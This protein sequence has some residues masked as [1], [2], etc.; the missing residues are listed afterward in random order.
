MVKNNQLVKVAKVLFVVVTFIKKLYFHLF[1]ITIRLKQF[2]FFFGSFFLL[3]SCTYLDVNKSKKEFIKK[4]DTLVDFNSV[5]AFPLFPIC[6]DVP[7][8]EKQQICFQL[9]MSQYIYAGIKNYKVM[10]N[11]E[12]NDTVFVKLIVDSKGKTRLSSIKMSKQ[13]SA[14]FPKFDSI[15]KVSIDSLPNLYPAIK[16]SVPV[17]TE[18]TLPIILKN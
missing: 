9:N 11:R 17:T 5:D 12:I 4:V 1:K 16:R 15:V 10:V 3:F 14:L 18:F 13:T 6:K 2:L 7:S 8:R